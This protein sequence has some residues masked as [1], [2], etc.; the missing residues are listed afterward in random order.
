MK[1]SNGMKKILPIIIV[2]IILVGAS[3]FY[4]GMKYQQS[5]STGSKAQGNFQ[6]FRNLT[7]EQRQ[8]MIEQGG[9]NLPGGSTAG[10]TGNRTAGNLARGE[11]I[12]KDDKSITIKLG[13]QDGGSK[14]IFFSDATKITKSA[15]GLSS[16][17]EIGKTVMVGGQQN[18]DGS[19]TAETIQLN[20]LTP[21][22]Q[23]SQ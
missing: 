9:A 18:S 7:P 15:E 21:S 13:G 23:S 12:A 3:A 22:T 16:D 1:I 11:I 5:Q 2:V 10:R 4:S 14:I 20:S 19:M 6:N 8:Q 17:L